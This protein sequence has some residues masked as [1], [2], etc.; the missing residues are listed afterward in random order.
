[1]SHLPW[2]EP[3][4]LIFPTVNLNNSKN[5]V[6]LCYSFP[7]L[8]SKNQF[9][10]FAYI[11]YDPEKSAYCVFLWLL[12]KKLLYLQNYLTFI[13]FVAEQSKSN[14]HQTADHIC[15]TF[16]LK[17]STI[18][19]LNW[20]TVPKVYFCRKKTSPSLLLTLLY[21][22]LK[23]NMTIYKILKYIVTWVLWRES[24]CSTCSTLWRITVH[25]KKFSRGSQ[26]FVL[27]K[28]AWWSST[29]LQY[30]ISNTK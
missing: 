6:A 17:F 14:I 5:Q 29:R 4:C 9:V 18:E 2:Q 26:M 22:I 11:Y 10:I 30:K 19:T 13:H 23:P 12:F 8:H 1:M 28:M 27:F 24:V 3:S 7:E 15:N 16:S 25:L 21:Y 20:K